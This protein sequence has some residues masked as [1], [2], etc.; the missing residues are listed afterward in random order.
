MKNIEQITFNNSSD[1]NIFLRILIEKNVC[2]IKH[3]K[4]NIPKN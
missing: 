3:N 2:K 1:P 4:T